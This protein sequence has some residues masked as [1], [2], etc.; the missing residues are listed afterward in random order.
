[1]TVRFRLRT[2]LVLLAVGPLL[3]AC[4]WWSLMA[5]RAEQARQRALEAEEA[6]KARIAELIELTTW[7]VSN[8]K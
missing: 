8:A 4:A 6:E 7:Q 1:M 3:L 2:L 5:W